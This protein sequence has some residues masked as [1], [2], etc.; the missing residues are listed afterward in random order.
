MLL[1]VMQLAVLIRLR[2]T[3]PGAQKSSNS[4]FSE[5]ILLEKFYIGLDPLTLSVTNNATGGCFMSKMFARIAITLDKITKHNQAWHA[6]D[7][8]WGISIGALSMTHFIKE[9]KGNSRMPT[10]L[11]MH[12]GVVR[13]RT[14]RDKT[15]PKLVETITA[16]LRQPVWYE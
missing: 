12:K 4:W 16:R 3:Q 9:N 8:S 2:V 13:G 15:N 6:G 11:T 1:R 14:A 5:N 7:N 10:T